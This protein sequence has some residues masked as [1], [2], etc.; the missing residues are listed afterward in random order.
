MTS[1]NCKLHFPLYE[2]A[3]PEN[4]IVLAM[5]FFELLCG[6]CDNLVLVNQLYIYLF[7][8]L[9]ISLT[10]VQNFSQPAVFGRFRSY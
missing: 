2:F 5:S 4:M 6:L 10:Y 1:I 9:F 8:Y 3:C 7:V